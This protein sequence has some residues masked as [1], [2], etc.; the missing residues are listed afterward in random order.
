MESQLGTHNKRC[1]MRSVRHTRSTIYTGTI[2]RGSDL[3]PFPYYDPW[4]LLGA[5]W[6]GG[7]DI[8]APIY[9][10]PVGTVLAV[11]LKIGPA[12]NCDVRLCTDSNLLLSSR[13]SVQPQGRSL[14]FQAQKSP[15][16]RNLGFTCLLFCTQFILV[17]YL[18]LFPV[19]LGRKKSSHHPFSCERFRGVELPLVF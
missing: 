14:P 8:L 7:L 12:V 19:Y 10:F 5:R 6:H 4:F 17:N 3:L 2:R 11:S 1:R 18:H 15:D 16:P 9:F 13:L